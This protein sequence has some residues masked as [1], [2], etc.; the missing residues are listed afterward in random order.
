MNFF[1]NTDRK[2]YPNAP[3]SAYAHIGNGANIIYVDPDHD[4]VM[5]VRWIE[6]SAM[7][8]MIGKLMDAMK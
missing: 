4:L 2:Y 5:V 8:E 7:N 6:A 3:A 1:L